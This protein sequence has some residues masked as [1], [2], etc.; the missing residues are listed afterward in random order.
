[1][2][3]SSR[4]S[5]S[6]RYPHQNPVCT[7]PLPYSFTCLTSLIL[8]YLIPRIIFGDNYDLLGLGSITGADWS[9]NSIE[10]IHPFLCTSLRS[11]TESTFLWL[12][13]A[14]FSKTVNEN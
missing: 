10:D 12:F 14:S 1:M 5:P 13:S 2:P 4:W 9:C 8:L 6:R 3:G 7:S 11:G